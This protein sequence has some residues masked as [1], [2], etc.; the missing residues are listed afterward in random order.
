MPD[1]P[2]YW[3]PVVL[4]GCVLVAVVVSWLIVEALDRLGLCYRASRERAPKVQ[5]ATDAA[6][7]LHA[8]W[9]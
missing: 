2:W 6:R 9:R 5:R 3:W 8:G 7:R 1:L 4:A